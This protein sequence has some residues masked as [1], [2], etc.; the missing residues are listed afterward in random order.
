M[1]YDEASKSL[2]GTKFVQPK[3]WAKN[4]YKA[5][6]MCLLDVPY[7]GHNPQINNCFKFL[8]S[9]LHDGLLSLDK[10]YAIDA[11][12]MRTISGPS[13]KGED[14]T[15]IIQVRHAST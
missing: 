6:I 12:L 10:S 11:K 5:C 4:L 8:L 15:T 1:V 9:R 7:L 3:R 13:R 14:P 2:D